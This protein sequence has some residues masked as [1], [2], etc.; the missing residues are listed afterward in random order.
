MRFCNS[1]T[2]LVLVLALAVAVS[3]AFSNGRATTEMHQQR[4]LVDHDSRSAGQEASEALLNRV[5]SGVIDL[6]SH[7]SVAGAQTRS[8]TIEDVPGS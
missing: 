4:D 7:K 5:T 8:L 6:S 2:W 3:D 1:I